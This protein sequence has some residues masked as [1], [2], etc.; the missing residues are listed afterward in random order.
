MFPELH[1]LKFKLCSKAHN[2]KFVFHL[3]VA[4]QLS[5]GWQHKYSTKTRQ[6]GCANEQSMYSLMSMVNRYQ[7]KSRLL[8]FCY[9]TAFSASSS[10]GIFVAAT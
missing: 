8:K 9:V 3:I 2:K 10:E 1:S 5:S 7:K 6:A 4:L